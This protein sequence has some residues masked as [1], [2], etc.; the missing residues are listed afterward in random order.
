MW[1]VG[2]GLWPSRGGF[3]FAEDS[4]FPREEFGEHASST[5]STP[6]GRG[7][8]KVERAFSRK[9]R[10]RVAGGRGVF[11]VER[12]CSR[13]VWWRVSGGAGVLRV[14]RAFSRKGWPQT[15]TGIL[16]LPRLLTA[17]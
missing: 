5:L 6:G 16:P 12:A 2:S 9:G 11:K 3:D 4:L 14:E 1:A 7:V 15:S 10:A 17:S 8:F 13:G